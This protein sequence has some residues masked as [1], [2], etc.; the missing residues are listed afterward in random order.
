[1]QPCL[2]VLPCSVGKSVFPDRWAVTVL[3]V[4]EQMNLKPESLIVQLAPKCEQGGAELQA[5]RG[6]VNP[7]VCL[8]NSA[9]GGTLGPA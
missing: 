6:V 7:R 9:W 5:R 1:M 3:D 2:I 8:G 4:K